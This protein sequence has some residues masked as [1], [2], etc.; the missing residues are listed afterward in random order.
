GS[1]GI[2]AASQPR[3]AIIGGGIAGLN[4]ALTLLDAGYASTVYEAS[5]RIGGRMHS[6][7]TSWENGQVSEHCGE[8]IDSTHKT[9]LSLAKRFKIP[10]A[11]LSAAEPTQST[12]TYYFFG[13]YYPRSQAVN[14]FKPVYQAL[15]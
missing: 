10:V 5:T 13:N 12:E 6:D 7:T 3:V 15:K 11:D 8:L 2:I 9:I 4:A 1:R 14:D